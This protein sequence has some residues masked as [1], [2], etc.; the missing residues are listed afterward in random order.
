MIPDVLDCVRQIFL[1]DFTLATHPAATCWYAL[2]KQARLFSHFLVVGFL[3]KYFTVGGIISPV[4][5][6]CQALMR[7]LFKNI[8]LLFYLSMIMSKNRKR[9]NHLALAWMTN[10]LHKKNHLIETYTMKVVPLGNNILET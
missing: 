8:I 3:S 2:T 5:T 7:Y 9:G 10:I 6:W 4:P 1:P